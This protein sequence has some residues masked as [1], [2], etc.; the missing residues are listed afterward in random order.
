M[1]LDG[2]DPLAD[3][4]LDPSHDPA[5]VDRPV[6][7][8]VWSDVACPWCYIGLR[9]FAVGADAFGASNGIDVEVTFHSYELAPDTPVD[10]DGSE[11][12]F[13][14]RHKQLPEARVRDL[15]VRVGEAAEASGLTIDFHAIRHTNTRK[16]HEL[17]HHARVHGRQRA[18]KERLLRAYFTE[19]RHLGRIDELATL[20][21]DVGLDA[22]AAA[23]ALHEAVYAAAV[24]ADVR[25]ARAYG[26]TG[27]PFFVL[28]ETFGVSGA[29]EPETFAKALLRTITERGAAS[30]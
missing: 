16:A 12:D 14:I 1:T 13:L 19:G 11:I 10:F 9:R 15:L 23:R 4:A 27:V 17:L 20:A 26:L 29:Q 28:D 2:A 24:E 6:R 5:G 18:M 21:G 7:V 8:D 3:P 25:M 30:D 22:D